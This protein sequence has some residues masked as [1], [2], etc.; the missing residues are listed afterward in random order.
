MLVSMV[1]TPPSSI[2]SVVGSCPVAS[3]SAVGCVRSLGGACVGTAGGGV[4]CGATCGPGGGVGLGVGVWRGCAGV[5]CGVGVCD[6]ATAVRVCVPTR[7][8]RPV[9]CRACEDGIRDPARA[10]RTSSTAPRRAR[11]DEFENSLRLIFFPQ[12]FA[13][14]VPPL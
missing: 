4:S 6:G 5:L 12:K 14:R 8:G 9:S 2:S 13:P 3:G 7:R 11:F 1:T 10:S